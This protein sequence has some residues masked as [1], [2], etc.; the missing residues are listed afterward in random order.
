VAVPPTGCPSSPDR[1]APLEWAERTEW[2]KRL[3]RLERLE[4]LISGFLFMVV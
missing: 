1:P 4:R 2:L 3:E